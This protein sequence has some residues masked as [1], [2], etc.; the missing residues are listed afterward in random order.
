MMRRSLSKPVSP[1]PLI[2]CRCQ[3]QIDKTRGH[4]RLDQKRS[5]GVV[6]G[7]Q[8]A[9]HIY[10]VRSH[11]FYPHFCRGRQR[12]AVR[13]MDRWLRERRLHFRHCLRDR[14]SLHCALRGCCRIRVGLLTSASKWRERT[15]SMERLLADLRLTRASDFHLSCS[16]KLRVALM[17][18]RAVIEAPW[19]RLALY[20]AS[21]VEC[22]ARLPPARGDQRRHRRL[23]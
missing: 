4:L 16:K 10:V 14:R 6:T 3:F 20:Q 18:E 19:R 22:H 8:G 13:A 17:H 9:S 11:N 15:Q 2:G 7:S 23:D 12:L 1:S 21:A 5:S